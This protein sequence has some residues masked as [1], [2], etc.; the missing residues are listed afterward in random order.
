M[1]ELIVEHLKYGVHPVQNTQ[2]A[3]DWLEVYLLLQGKCTYLIN[4]KI[5]NVESGDLIIIPEHTIHLAQYSDDNKRE[6]ILL[7]LPFNYISHHIRSDIYKLQYVYRCGDKLDEIKDIFF[8]IYDNF[9][10]NDKFSLLL[11]KANISRLFALLLRSNNKQ[12]YTLEPNRDNLISSLLSYISNNYNTDLTLHKLADAFYISSA[13]LSRIF[14]AHTGFCF[15][16]Y[17]GLYRLERAKEYLLET[18]LPVK[19]IATKCGFPDSN[20]FTV[21]FKKEVGVTPK[22]FRRTN[23]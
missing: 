21:K 10:Q 20:Y 16:E 11:M 15:S 17:L 22:E 3:H 6:R 4:N 9:R 7:S 5:Y 13:H 18:S 2:H 23:D 8:E 14:K 12:E 19:D 1:N